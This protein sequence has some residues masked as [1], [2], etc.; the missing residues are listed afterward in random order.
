MGNLSVSCLV[1]AVHAVSLIWYVLSHLP[2]IMMLT[3]RQGL[4]QALEEYDIPI[5]HIGG[6]ALHTYLLLS[7]V[8]TFGIRM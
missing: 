6:T 8:E 3:F 7:V 1:V 2:L 4:L 5:D